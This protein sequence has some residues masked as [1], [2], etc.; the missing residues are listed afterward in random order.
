MPKGEEPKVP[1]G[2][3][4][5]VPKGEEPKVPRSEGPNAQREP[6]ELKGAKPGGSSATSV[7]EVLLFFAGLAVGLMV[8]PLIDR[9]AGGVSLGRT[10]KKPPNPNR[11]SSMNENP[12]N[13]GQSAHAD[14]PR[15]PAAVEASAPGF[16]P[17]PQSS[18]H[19]A[20]PHAPP[21]SPLELA[22]AGQG[23]AELGN[24]PKPGVGSA[25]VAAGAPSESSE[26]GQVQT[27]SG[28]PSPTPAPP[29]E[30]VPKPLLPPTGEPDQ[31]RKHLEKIRSNMAEIFSKAEGGL[32][33][34]RLGLIG[35][36][37]ED[38]V[39]RLDGKDENARWY[40]VGDLHGDFLAWHYLFERVRKE[41][42]FRL[43]F[44]G[45]LVDRGPLDIEVFAALME[46]VQENPG[47]ILWIAG[48][49]DVAIRQ[50]DGAFVSA[51]QPAEFVDWLN[52]P[53]GGLQKDEVRP[54]GELFIR[55]CQILPRAALLP[56]G[57]LAVHGGVPLEDRW[58]SLGQPTSQ[59]DERTLADFTWT[60]ATQVPSKQ[61][62]KYDPERRKKSSAFEFGYKDL[63]GFQ[64]AV[65]D[66][67]PVACL[68]RGHD[69]VEG[70]HEQPREYAGLVPLL[71][72]N[73]F[74]FNH[75]N[76][77][78]AKYREWLVLGCWREGGLPGVERV[79]YHREDYLAMYCAPAAP[80]N[81]TVP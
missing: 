36:N 76:N 50:K 56:G 5:K 72:L 59:W 35:L 78:V 24:A 28:S 37:G 55:I 34:G 30:E 31:A 79:A 17:L 77:S 80:E 20:L 73:G 81:E 14:P 11:S 4:P 25:T 18:K 27:G 15:N 33:E 68:V 40:F 42:N 12:R 60:R 48:N 66:T 70:G 53:P 62:W 7:K 71:T 3:E 65:K 43:C 9:L 22:A 58:E 16:E 6:A 57:V 69:H 54:W 32:A 41:E 8:G 45:D 75:I 26:K 1:K 47:R 51:V 38:R 74:G 39:Q 49:H 67:L 44:L 10:G 29:L 13:A 61:G 23:K 46:A 64:N 52:A 63:A 21:V 2:E 19:A